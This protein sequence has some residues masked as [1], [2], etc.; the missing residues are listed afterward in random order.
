MVGEEGRDASAIEAEEPESRTSHVQL[1]AL[2]SNRA[3]S[4]H[5]P[6]ASTDVSGTPLITAGIWLVNKFVQDYSSRSYP[7]DVS[8]QLGKLRQASRHPY[9]DSPNRVDNRAHSGPEK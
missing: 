4:P 5:S 7:T 2:Y 3:I 1:Q 9:E 8:L 6:L